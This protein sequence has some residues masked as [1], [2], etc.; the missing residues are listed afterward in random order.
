[1]RV[2]ERSTIQEAEPGGPRGVAAFPTATVMRDGSIL[3]TYSVGSG[4]DTDDIGL[5]LR[6]SVDGGRTWSGAERPFSTV[7]DGVKG[8]VK[9]G[10][11]TRL[12]G[13]AAIL[14]GLWI[15]REAF[16]GSPLFD[17]DTEGC[18]PMRVVLSDT[19]DDG[20]TWS[21]WRWIDT[22]EDVGPPS[23]TAPLLRLPGGR[24]LVSIE[25]NKT[26]RDRSK[27]LQRVVYMAS[28]DGGHTW[29]D[30]WTAVADPTGQIANWDQRTA[31]TPDGKLVSFTWVY[32]FAAVAYRNVTRRLSPDGGRTW[33]DPEDLGFSDQPSV[34][35]ILPDGRT[36][37]AWTDRY[38][39]RSI[40]ARAAA[41]YDA[42]FEPSTEIAVF[43]RHPAAPNTRREG[44]PEGDTTGEALV[45]MASWDYGLAFAAALP[46][47]DA[48]VL[49]YAPGSGGGTDIRWNR[50]RLDPTEAREWVGGTTPT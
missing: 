29:S 6:R 19:T 20:R 21:P 2:V 12:D 42:A 45:E 40:R 28:D 39:T 10:Y 47:G 27:W 24:L 34:P 37:L 8:S 13:N 22:P 16:P 18:L 31:V 49:H 9:V 23:L 43:E 7:L 14:V 33:T 35:A 4:K 44:A 3:A 1:M 36:V 17:P 11:V 41:A 50:L 15:D 26:Y 25:S 46:D 32:D 30:S 38:G 48:A 5:E